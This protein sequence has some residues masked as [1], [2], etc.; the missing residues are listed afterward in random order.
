MQEFG[1]PPL[2][3]QQAMQLAALH[4]RYSVTHT[5]LPA[6]HLYHLRRGKI[7]SNTHPRNSIESR[8]HDACTELRLKDTYPG[9][10][11]SLMLSK[12]QKKRIGV[13]KPYNKYLKG[14][15]NDRW[16]T[17][18]LSA[19]P[20][21]ISLIDQSKQ[22]P[23]TRSEAYQ[24]IRSHTPKADIHKVASY[25]SPYCTINPYPLLRVRTQCHSYYATSSSPPTSPPGGQCHIYTV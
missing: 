8:I 13:P 17:L 18:L 9:P 21:H 6:A 23:S 1:I 3:L 4:F 15:V 5:H 19:L 10:H 22:A 20:D 25:L 24:R 11:R 14:F 2:K 16:R 12:R 7:A